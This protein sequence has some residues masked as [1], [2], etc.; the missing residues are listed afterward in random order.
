MELN[1]IGRMEVIPQAPPPQPSGR[2]VRCKL[3]ISAEY[4]SDLAGLEGS[5]N[6]QVLFGPDQPS[7]C[8]RFGKA[9]DGVAAW[10]PWR[11]SGLQIATVRLRGIEGN[12]L[13][14]DGLEPEPGSLVYDLM[15]FTLAWAAEPSQEQL[16]ANPRQDFVSSVCANDRARLL[17]KAA[18]IHGHYCPGIA[19]GVM[20]SLCGLKGLGVEHQVFDGLM[21][22][23]LA[24]VEINACFTDGVQAVSGCTLGN[25]ALVFRDLGHTAVT[26]VQ[27]DRKEG[28]RIRVKPEFRDQV[29]RLAQDFYPLMEKVIMQRQG[30]AQDMALFKEQA[31]QAALGLIELDFQDLFVTQWVTPHLPE[32]APISPLVFCSQCKE[33]VSAS[34]TLPKGESAAMCFSCAGQPVSQVDGRGILKK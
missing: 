30:N 31:R 8:P 33:P 10:P 25:N 21:E 22:E 4:S 23:L 24:I 27:R 15:P 26:F 18:E 3:I 20:A 5:K 19:L 13:W 7:E 11:P 9:K 28:L 1:K 6:I 29:T 34:K 16:I 12:V 14:V 32:H 17:V 2:P